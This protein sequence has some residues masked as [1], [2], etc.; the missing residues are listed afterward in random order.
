[1]AGAP[2][3]PDEKGAPGDE[4][5]SVPVD[6][7]RGEDNRNTAGGA[8]VG[9]DRGRG[10]EHR[11]VRELRGPV[12]PI[13]FV[14]VGFLQEGHAPGSMMVE[15]ATLLVVEGGGMIDEPPSIPDEKRRRLARGGTAMRVKE[16]GDGVAAAELPPRDALGSDATPQDTPKGE[17]RAEQG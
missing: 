14:P 9:P 10:R 12:P 11:P 6:K 1:M 2:L 3:R 16:V 5:G 13:N 7:V 4:D 8:A 17:R 15:K